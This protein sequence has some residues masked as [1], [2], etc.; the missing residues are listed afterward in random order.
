MRIELADAAAPHAFEAGWNCCAA[1]RRGLRSGAWPMPLDKAVAVDRRQ[2]G[3]ANRTNCNSRDHTTRRFWTRADR[4]L[5]GRRRREPRRR[6]TPDW[7]SRTGSERPRTAREFVRPC[8][9]HGPLV[10]GASRGTAADRTWDALPGL[11]TSSRR[12]R[13]GRRC[14]P[15]PIRVG[16]S[17]RR[18]RDHHRLTP[19]RLEPDPHVGPALPARRRA[20]RA[21]LRPR[22]PG[23]VA[24]RVFVRRPKRPRRRTQLPFATAFP[25]SARLGSAPTSVATRSGRGVLSTSCGVRRSGEFDSILWT[26]ILSA[27]PGRRI[28]RRGCALLCSAFE[29]LSVEDTGLKALLAA[30]DPNK[31]THLLF[32]QNAVTDADCGRGRDPLGCGS[33]RSTSEATRSRRRRRGPDAGSTRDTFVSVDEALYPDEPEE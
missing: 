2:S 8:A 33:R 6:H 27:T 1:R 15:K 28:G 21:P 9:G 31:V 7:C 17:I 25:P 10:P 12:G 29:V 14:A 5:L 11:A 24:V 16:F 4:P 18:T 20:A 3:S 26:A 13:V 23:V 32:E 19:V 22:R 30:V